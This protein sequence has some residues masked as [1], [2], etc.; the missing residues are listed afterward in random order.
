MDKSKLQNEQTDNL[1]KAILQ[2][3]TLDDCY[4]FFD[5]LCTITEL[6]SM[7]QRFEVAALL[8]EGLTF[9]MISEKTGAS[10][11]TITRVNKC[12]Q[13]GDGYVKILRRNEETSNE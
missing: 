13:Y 11:A 5:D 1:F 10:T 3:E 2:L 8:N 12:L 6:K 7:A 9:T 4:A